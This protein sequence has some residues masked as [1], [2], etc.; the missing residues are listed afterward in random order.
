MPSQTG[1]PSQR[2]CARI[3]GFL[4]IAEIVFVLVG[5]FFLSRIEG[6]GTFAETA[7]RIAASEHAYRAALSTVVIVTLCSI[8]LGFTLYV[9]LRPVHRLLAQLGMIFWLADSFLGLVVRMCSFVQVHLYL[10]A[11]TAGPGASAAEGFFD[12]VRNMGRTTENIGGISFG[13]GSLLFFCLFFRSGYIPKIVSVLGL[14]ASAIWALLYFAN[15]IFPEHHGLFQAICLPPMA[16]AD[17]ATGFYLALFA[18]R[19]GVQPS[20][21]AE[22]VSH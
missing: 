8:V 15:L 18:V 6:N 22:A 11:L 3:A 2:T 4:Y 10:S 1:T 20:A 19:T 13:L 7:R 17:V 21:I 12:L 5:G 16:L 14:A 9:T